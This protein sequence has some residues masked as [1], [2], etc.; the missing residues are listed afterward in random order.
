MGSLGGASSIRSRGGIS[1]AISMA[2][3]NRS[4]SM[5]SISLGSGTLVSVDLDPLVSVVEVDATGSV[6]E[7]GETAST[8]TEKASASG[9]PYPFFSS[10]RHK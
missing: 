6:T 4:G 2:S 10:Y 9:G 1:P 3:R 5:L 7:G 8:S